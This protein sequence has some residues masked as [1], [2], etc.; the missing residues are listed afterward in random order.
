MLHTMDLAVKAKNIVKTFDSV[1]ALN[2]VSFSIPRGCIF[3]YLGPN[4]A[5]KT[6]TIRIL[7]NLLEPD[8]GHIEIL[9][10]DIHG[11]FDTVKPSIGLM[12]AERAYLAPHLTIKRNLRLFGRLYGLKGQ[13][14]KTKIQEL[15]DFFGMS[16][17]QDRRVYELSRGLRVRASLCKS[18]VNAPQLLFLDEPTSGIDVMYTLQI[19]RYIKDI[20]KQ[21]CTVF[22]TTH[23]MHEAQQLSEYVAFLDKGQLIAY[24]RTNELLQKLQD[25]SSVRKIRVRCDK[26][27]ELSTALLK[28]DYEV[29][30]MNDEIYVKLKLTEDLN[31]PLLKIASAVKVHSISVIE[32]SLEDLFKLMCESRGEKNDEQK[33]EEKLPR[34]MGNFQDRDGRA[35]I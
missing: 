7:T 10:H 16:K 22:L 31:T 21:G 2:D 19:R 27:E 34:F 11:E 33:M 6:T 5:G 20:S 3:G 9:G 23:D 17:Y 29:E 35:C 30:K 14:L 4:G 24:G 25:I 1:V 13:E 15:L 8:S 12:S 18:L 28:D 26:P 32:P